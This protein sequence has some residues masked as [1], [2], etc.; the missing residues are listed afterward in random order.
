MNILFVNETCGYFGGVEQNVADAAVGLRAR[1]HTCYLAYGTVTERDVDTYQG[2][3]DGC[4]PCSELNPA[5]PTQPAYAFETVLHQITPDVVYVHKAPTIQFCV[6]RLPG[7]RTV[8][9]VHDH[10]LCCPR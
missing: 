3:F 5:L 10:D 6:H 4:F 1:G 7:V 9:M 8:R 2:L